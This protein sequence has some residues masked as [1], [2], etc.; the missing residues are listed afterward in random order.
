MSVKNLTV[1]LDCSRNAIL[2][3]ENVK[4]FVDLISKMGYNG[5]MLYTEDTFEVEGEKFFGYKRGKYTVKEIIEIRDYCNEKGVELI[6]CIQTLAHLGTIFRWKEY[7]NICDVNDILLIDD[8]RTYVLIE[9]IFKTLSKAFTSR[10]VHIGMDEAYMVGL[11]K[12]MQKYGSQDKIDLLI[13]HL[14]KVVEISQKYGFR[15]MMW[16]DMFFRL[17]SNG[18]YY[19]GTADISSRKEIKGLL[20]SVDIV[21]WDYYSTEKKHY[22][23][24][25]YAHNAL[26]STPIFAGG[27]W[28]WNGFAPYNCFSQEVAKA[29]LDSC[30]DNGVDEVI[31]TMWRDH[32]AECSFFALLPALFY[33]AQTAKGESNLNKIKQEFFELTGIDYDVFCSLDLPNAISNKTK[34]DNPCKNLFYN[35]VFL[36]IFDCCVPEGTFKTYSENQKILRANGEKAGEYKYL[37]D[38]MSALCGVLAIKCELGI[39]T[40]QLY[41]KQDKEGLKRLAENEY[42]E[43]INRIEE[44]Y[45]KFRAVWYKENKTYG[46]EVQDIRIG[47]LIC[48]IKNCRKMLLDYCSGLIDIIEELEEEVFDFDGKD[49]WQRETSNRNEW[50]IA[51]TANVV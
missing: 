14:G 24:M 27:I 25:F 33:S 37:F 46:F 41:K 38:C 31:F 20:E 12:Y 2:T 51:V 9:N 45:E 5:L 8:E 40:Q 18:E 26:T 7:G 10:R 1:M 16:S 36:R 3:V 28:S 32:G 39:K 23:E 13:K 21:Y 43:L 4:K 50:Y 35:D 19:G 34:T 48:R 30:K 17:L 22:D 29:S 44:F 15:P 49:E 42:F 6:P 11:G 47:G